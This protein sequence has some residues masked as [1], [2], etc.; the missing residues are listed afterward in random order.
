MRDSFNINM[1]QVWPTV[2]Q[3]IALRGFLKFANHIVNVLMTGGPAVTT[4]NKGKSNQ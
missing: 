1:E 2:Q 4:F 3:S